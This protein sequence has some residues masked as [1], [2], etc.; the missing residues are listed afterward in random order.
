MA[1]SYPRFIVKEIFNRLTQT[2]PDTNIS[3]LKKEA[4]FPTVNNSQ[5][6]ASDWFFQDD[7]AVV[8]L[9][10]ISHELNFDKCHE[11]ETLINHLSTK[12]GL[13]N[14]SPI[15]NDLFIRRMNSV[16][17]QDYVDCVLYSQRLFPAV[18]TDY[19]FKNGKLE[20][21]QQCQ[22]KEKDFYT[23]Q[24][25]FLAM[26]MELKQLFNGLGVDIVPQFY[27]NKNGVPNEEGFNNLGIG[28]VVGTKEIASVVIDLKNMPELFSTH[29]R[30][31]HSLV[32]DKFKSACHI[33]NDKTY[34]A[35]I[36]RTKV[37]KHL[38]STGRIPTANEISKDLNM[39]KSTFYRRLETENRTYGEITKEITLSIACNLL[40][41]TT[42]SIEN[43]SIQIGYANVSAF[44]R[45]FKSMLNQTPTEYRN[46]HFLC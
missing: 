39:G 14:F 9:L 42:E 8:N 16:N 7:E 22:T 4:K 23:P 33:N 19:K 43:I 38:I 20:V 2:Y 29:N 1:Y 36:V 13:D 32:T 10:R 44:T 27:F 30:L 21:T 40:E 12:P 37:K 28:E 6:S 41:N 35:E 5:T 46:N 15:L 25:A 26:G 11:I 31:I 17:I 18:T 3:E 34:F 45:S 24:S